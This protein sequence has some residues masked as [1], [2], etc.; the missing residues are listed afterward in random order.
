MDLSEY[1]TEMQSLAIASAMEEVYRL[2]NT[3]TVIPEAW[4]FLPQ[5]RNTPVKMAGR[6]ADPKGPRRTTHVARLPGHHRRGQARN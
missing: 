6:G 5:A 2:R 4:E 1:S 3:I